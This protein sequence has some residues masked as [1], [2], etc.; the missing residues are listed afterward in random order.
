MSVLPS[1]VQNALA[2]LLQGLSSSDNAIRTTAEEQLNS[3]WVVARP[4]VLL[5]G[6][7]EHVHSDPDGVVRSS[8]LSYS[9]LVDTCLLDTFVRCSA[10]PAHSYKK[11]KGLK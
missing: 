9:S 5:M 2:Q 6:L 1:D 4:D 8:A 7:A 11:P 10:L 3:E